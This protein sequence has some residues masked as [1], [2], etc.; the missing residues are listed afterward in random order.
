MPV[1]CKDESFEAAD[2]SSS[3]NSCHW[4]VTGV[5]KVHCKPVGA[6]ALPCTN[7]QDIVVGLSILSLEI[8][9]ATSWAT[10]L[11]CATCWTLG[12]VLFWITLPVCGKTDHPPFWSSAGRP[13]MRNSSERPSLE[14]CTAWLPFKGFA[15]ICRAFSNSAG[16]MTVAPFNGIDNW[17]LPSCGMHSCLQTNQL[18]CNWMSSALSDEADLKVLST[19]TGVTSKTLSS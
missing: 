11:F 4:P 15:C 9:I 14:I 8:F 17:K 10:L 12:T 3:L 5:S 7:N 16:A 6:S 1:G 19:V 13:S 18:A 2:F